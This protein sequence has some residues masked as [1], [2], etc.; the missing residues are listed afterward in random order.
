MVRFSTI[1]AGLMMI[2]IISPLNAQRL[3]DGQK[4]V[5]LFMGVPFQKARQIDKNHSMGIALTCNTKT[6]N[7]WRF[8]GSYNHKTMN[9]KQWEIPYDLYQG[10]VGYFLQVLTNYRRNFMIYTGLS[11]IGGY[12]VFNDDK[13]IL[14]DGAMVCILVF[15]LIKKSKE[16]EIFNN[17]K[18]TIFY[19][20]RFVSNLL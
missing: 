7:Y 5:E 13:T 18:F 19:S 8:G 4:S 20:N 15:L 12:E 2:F 17:F 16:N 6:E 10:E 11:A 9:Y 3:L 1:I 14:Q